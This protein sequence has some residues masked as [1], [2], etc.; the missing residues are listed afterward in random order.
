MSS[1]PRGGAVW[2]LVGLILRRSQFRTLNR[3]TAVGVQLL[4]PCYPGKHAWC[5]ALFPL[6]RR[7]IACCL[8]PSGRVAP[9][10]P[11]DQ[12][13]APSQAGRRPF[14]RRRDAG[15]AR[16]TRPDRRPGKL[17]VTNETRLKPHESEHARAWSHCLPQQAFGRWHGATW[18]RASAIRSPGRSAAGGLGEH[19][20]VHVGNELVG[21]FEER[22]VS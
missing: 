3:H 9:F 10:L 19:R 12:P 16:S 6:N 7:G 21:L 17:P 4:R 14:S 15:M 5:R 1:S 22:S 2:S 18:L 8:S 20:V 13:L 11:R